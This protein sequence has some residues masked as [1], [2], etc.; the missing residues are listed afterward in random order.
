MAVL[1]WHDD[2][3]VAL[4]FA[5]L[6]SIDTSVEAAKHRWGRFALTSRARALPRDA[7]RGPRPRGPM[8]CP[9]AALSR[10]E[11]GTPN[12]LWGGMS[13]QGKDRQQETPDLLPRLADVAN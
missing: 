7:P 3:Q 9:S 5:E 8:P 6:V 13:A 1:L 4:Q 11:K 10:G 12:E 2:R